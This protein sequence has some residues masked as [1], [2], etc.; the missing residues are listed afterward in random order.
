MPRTGAPPGDAPALAARDPAEHLQPL[1]ELRDRE[2]SLLGRFEVEDEEVLEVRR[3]HI[4]RP[5]RQLHG[6]EIVAGLTDGVLEALAGGLVL[7]G[8]V[9]GPKPA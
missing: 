3:H 2:G 7:D 9:L 5:L 8:H 6:A 4:P 1:R